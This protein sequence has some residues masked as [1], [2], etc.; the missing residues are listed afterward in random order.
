MYKTP[1][2]IEELD[3][4]KRASD[5]INL[6]LNHN[7]IEAI[8][9]KY[10]A[11]R[12]SDGGHDGTIYDTKKDAVRHQ[13]FEQQCAYISFR[14]LAAGANAY[15]MAIYLKWCAKVY[16]SGMRMVDPDELN[17]GPDLIMSAKMVDA[18]KGRKRG[19]LRG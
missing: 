5:I 13:P 11:I 6:Y 4:G 7:Q 2:S 8:R 12:M 1:V 9:D 18:L 17:A 19:I 16:E 14:N 15:D 10:V 3:K